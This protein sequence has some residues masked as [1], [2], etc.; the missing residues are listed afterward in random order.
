MDAGMFVNIDSDNGLLPGG[1]K[2]VPLLVL[3]NCQG[4]LKKTSLF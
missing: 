3:S 4:N 2:P 1:T